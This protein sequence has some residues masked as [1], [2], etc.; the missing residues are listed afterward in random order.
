MKNSRKF[1]C[2]KQLIKGDGYKDIALQPLPIPLDADYQLKRVF[3]LIGSLKWGNNN[4]DILS[5]FSTLL[6]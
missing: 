1:Q 4:T 5:E 6:D 3:I 2:L